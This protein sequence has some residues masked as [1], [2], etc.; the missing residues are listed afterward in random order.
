GISVCCGGIIG[1]GESEDDRI[2]LLMELANLD[3][4]PE[5]VPVNHLVPV[6]GT[7]LAHAEPLDGVD[8]VRAIAAA[9]LMMPRSTVRLSAGRE[10]MSRELQALCFL[11]GAG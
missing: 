11:A 7:P 2:G 8:F 10:G 5:S 9:R 6:G 3:P 4:H 1:M